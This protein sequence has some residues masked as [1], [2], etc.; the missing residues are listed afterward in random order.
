VLCAAPDYLKRFGETLSPHDLSKHAC[1]CFPPLW[2]DGHW[3][4]VA[5]QRE[6]RVPVA[7]TIVTNG[8]EVLRACALGNAGNR[9]AAD[10]GNS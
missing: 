6:E 1:L 4:L 3:H 7:G 9:H 10:L 2:R 5:K 8:A